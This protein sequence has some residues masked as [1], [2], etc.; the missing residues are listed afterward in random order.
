MGRKAEASPGYPHVAPGGLEMPR[1]QYEGM[2]PFK[3]CT[4]RRS[5]A[6]DGSVEKRREKKEREKRRG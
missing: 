3:I 1:G 5:S 2:S 6:E 4:R